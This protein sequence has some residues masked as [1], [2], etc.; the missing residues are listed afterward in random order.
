MDDED[1]SRPSEYWMCPDGRDR[2]NNA[3]VSGDTVVSA[4]RPLQ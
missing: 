3:T 2:F 4:V 1:V